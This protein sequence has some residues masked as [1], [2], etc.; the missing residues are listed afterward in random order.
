VPRPLRLSELSPPRQVLVRLCQAINQGSIENLKVTN[1]EPVFDPLPMILQ[2][3]K[4][5]S[6]EGPRPEIHLIDFVVPAEVCRL[7]DRLDKLVTATIECIEVR[8]GIP[9]RVVLRDLMQE[10]LAGPSRFESGGNFAGDLN[11]HIRE[12]SKR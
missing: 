4:L 5:D 1:A 6:D 2:D 7:M 9:R 8:A 11:P 3:V 10:E 12:G